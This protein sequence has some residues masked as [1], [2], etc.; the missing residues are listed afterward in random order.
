[1]L[2]SSCFTLRSILTFFFNKSFNLNYS[3]L[4]ISSAAVN[5]ITHTLGLFCVI[6]TQP[7]KGECEKAF[8]APQVSQVLFTDLASVLVTSVVSHEFW[9]KKGGVGGG[10][11]RVVLYLYWK[12]KIIHVGTQSS[13]G[14]LGSHVCY[15][16]L[17]YS[18][19]AKSPR[20]E[21]QQSHRDSWSCCCCCMIS[22]WDVF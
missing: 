19:F 3:K 17:P 15:F 22:L 18:Q 20:H 2:I 12:I 5:R 11:K 13:A 6:H 7:E 8:A 10:E 9:F 14:R 4:L 1:M 16:H 21:H